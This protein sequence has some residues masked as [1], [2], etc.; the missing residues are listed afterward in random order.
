[1]KTI[2]SILF[3][4]FLCYISFVHGAKVSKKALLRQTACPANIA[5]NPDFWLTTYGLYCFDDAFK[6]P[7]HS[8]NIN[9]RAQ[10]ND[11]YIGVYDSTGTNRR[12]LIIFGG[13]ANTYTRAYR[14]DGTLMCEKAM[15]MSSDKFYDYNVTIEPV[16]NTLSVKQDGNV[17]FVC[18]MQ[19]SE[20]P[21]FAQYAFS[22]YCQGQSDHQVHFQDFTSKPAT[23]ADVP[24]VPCQ[25]KQN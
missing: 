13:W 10:G 12:M 4:A 17:A 9:F 16:T 18:Q 23:P 5:S 15:S 6:M 1:M 21:S 19:Q 11:W 8:A 7:D 3:F 24:P 2:S 22:C 14:A 20:V 25:R